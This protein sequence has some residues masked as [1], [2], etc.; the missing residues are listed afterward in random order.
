MSSVS[1]GPARRHSV[2]KRYINGQ[3]VEV[4]DHNTQAVL[5]QLHRSGDPE[6]QLEIRI[7]EHNSWVYWSVCQ[8]NPRIPGVEDRLVGGSAGTWQ[9]AFEQA[10]EA[11]QAE[12]TR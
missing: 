7:R 10:N 4:A 6:M 3:M 12:L 1:T 5:R 2:S 8:P 9:E 11:R